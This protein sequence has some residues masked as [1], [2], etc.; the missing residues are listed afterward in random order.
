MQ[1]SS[2]IL[3]LNSLFKRKLGKQHFCIELIT[4]L[5]SI[6]YHK[7]LQ[8][9]GMG[10][11][12]VTKCFYANLKW[13]VLFTKVHAVSS[14]ALSD[15][16]C[17]LYINIHFIENYLFISDFSCS[18]GELCISYFI[19]NGEMIRI[20]TLSSETVQNLINW[21]ALSL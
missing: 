14:K 8:I 1:Q 12:I 17:E 4:L 10:V 15:E 5:I 11:G 3:L 6:T 20:R 7:L 16:W 19:S 18:K 9:R 13:H 2:E 21:T